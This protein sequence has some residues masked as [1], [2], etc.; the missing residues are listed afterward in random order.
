MQ[1]Q[2]QLFHSEYPK[3]QL[4]E[5]VTKHFGVEGGKHTKKLFFSTNTFFYNNYSKIL[6][7]DIF[8]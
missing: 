6:L 7:A 4:L 2:G 1:L 8:V 5:T 3:P